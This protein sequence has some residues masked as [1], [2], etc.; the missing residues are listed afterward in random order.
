MTLAQFEASLRAGDRETRA[1]L[2]GKLM[3][4]AKPDDVFSHDARPRPLLSRAVFAREPNDYVRRLQQ[5]GL[6][7][8]QRRSRWILPTRSSSPSS[9]LLHRAEIRDLVDLQALLDRGGDLRGALQDA[10]KKDGGFSPLMVGYLLQNFPLQKQAAVAGLDA[11]AIAAL[12][13][14]RVDLAARIAALTQ[15]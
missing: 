6:R 4:Q 2:L 10:T 7:V 15:P 14:F 1:Y 3:R 8:A 12:D 13:R 11:T 5:L 9:A